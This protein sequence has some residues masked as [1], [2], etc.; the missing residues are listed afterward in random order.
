MNVDCRRSSTTHSIWMGSVVPSMACTP[1][2][3][4][5]YLSR[6]RDA[7]LVKPLTAR[8]KRCSGCVYSLVRLPFVLFRSQE[9]GWFGVIVFF[10]PLLL[11]RFYSTNPVAP[12]CSMY[13]SV[14]QL[15]EADRIN[16]LMYKF[17]FYWILCFCFPLSLS[18]FLSLSVTLCLFGFVCV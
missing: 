16:I 2:C 8:R 12:F 6:A 1:R 14:W 10:L 11:L 9:L 7:P 3:R 5:A 17:F 13:D 4:F 18:S 15:L